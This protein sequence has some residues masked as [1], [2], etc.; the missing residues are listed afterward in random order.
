MGLLDGISGGCSGAGELEGE[1]VSGSFS[2]FS[3]KSR[4]FQYFSPRLSTRG[5][6]I[7]R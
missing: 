1:V 5:M 2:S 4:T 3:Q 6:A 7:M